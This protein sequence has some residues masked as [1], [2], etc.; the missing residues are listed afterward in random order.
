M[1]TKAQVK[2]IRVL[3]TAKGREE[4]GAF[5]A[6]G[7]KLAREWL[8]APGDI[9]Y[10]VAVPEWIER[11][12]ELLARHPEAI[13]IPVSGDE[14]ARCS[15]LQNPNDALAVVPIPALPPALPRAEWCLALDRVQDPGNLGAIIRI[16]DWFGIG[17]VVCSPGCADYFNPKVIAAAMGGH[18]RVQLHV[19]D[20]PPFLSSCGMPV[21]AATLS[22]RPLNDMER[23]QAAVLII[24]NESKGIS[25]DVLRCA[26]MELT[27]PRRGGAESLNAAVSAGIIVASLLP[28]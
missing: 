22:G 18:L 25:A 17:H 14:L 5:L 10:L 2:E 16:A 8:S 13:V 26:G 27:I 15:S 24:G 12:G 21:L 11:N 9:R 19:T 23:L 6:E 3:A 7:D 20:L 28:D 1:I 4:H